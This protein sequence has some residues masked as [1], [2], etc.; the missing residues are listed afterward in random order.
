MEP[1]PRLLIVVPQAYL[2]A[3]IL[4]LH[5]YCDVH[6]TEHQTELLFGRMFWAMHLKEMIK[7]VVTNCKLCLSTKSFPKQLLQ[8]HTETTPETICS[9][10]AADVFVKGK[11]FLVLREVLTSHTS[12]LTI[13]DE[14][15]DTLKNAL[16]TL[17]SHYK[18]LK[19]IKIRVDNQSGFASLKSDKVFR[20][21]NIEIIPGDSKN[22]NKNPVAERAVRE[23]ED[24]I[25]KIQ[26]ADKEITIS[27]LAQ[28]TMAVNN[29]IRYIG[30]SAN[31][32]L[33]N[34]NALTGEKLKL[35]DE[36]LYL[37]VSLKTGRKFMIHLH[38]QKQ[39]PEEEN[40]SIQLLEEV[41]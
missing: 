2:R 14:K 19:T 5:A 8:Y 20:K 39:H 23:V 27:I 33:T 11:K 30:Y 22:V 34:T 3:L 9:H 15:A 12:T 24:E 1:K 17:L 4:Q 7:D 29:K 10:F 21:L 36:E 31:E 37:I 35:E 32:L 40:R 38:V 6:T 16:M 28:A 13:A 26:S 41:T 25:L 18:T